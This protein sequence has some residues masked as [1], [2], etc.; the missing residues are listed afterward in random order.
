VVEVAS[1]TSRGDVRRSEKIDDVAAATAYSIF[2]V[3]L[4]KKAAPAGRP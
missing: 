1:S 2:G 4:E 3:D